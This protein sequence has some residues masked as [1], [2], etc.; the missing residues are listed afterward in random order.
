MGLFVGELL[1]A[2]DCEG[3]ALQSDSESEAEEGFPVIYQ[4]IILSQA[5]EDIKNGYPHQLQDIRLFQE[6]SML[7]GVEGK[8]MRQQKSPWHETLC[9]RRAK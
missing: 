9:K 3:G 1:S 8:G 6:E 2:E 7:P 4:A 5:L